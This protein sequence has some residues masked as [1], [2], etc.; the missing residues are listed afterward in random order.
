MPVDFNGDEAAAG[1]ALDHLVSRG[2]HP[3][4]HL[5]RGLKE[6]PEIHTAERVAGRAVE[7]LAHGSSVDSLV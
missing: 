6:A 4:H 3:C 1:A 7:L 5:L 2:L